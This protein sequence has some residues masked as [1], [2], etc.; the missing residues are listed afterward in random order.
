MQFLLPS[1]VVL[2]LACIDVG[3]FLTTYFLK[4][5]ILSCIWPSALFGMFQYLGSQTHHT[6]RLSYSHRSLPELLRCARWIVICGS[7]VWGRHTYTQT[8]DKLTYRLYNVKCKLNCE[9][10]ELPVEM[11]KGWNIRIYVLRGFFWY[12]MWEFQNYNFI[13]SI[14]IF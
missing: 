7:F 9:L 6:K 4:W 5:S 14:F 8:P 3:L 11:V 13:I 12:I 1:K 2:N 10:L